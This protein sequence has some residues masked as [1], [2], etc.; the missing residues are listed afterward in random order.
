VAI[1][2]LV[3]GLAVTGVLTALSSEVYVR[4]QHRLLRLRARDATAVLTAALPSIQTPL[5]SAA[6]LA[7][8]TGGSAQKFRAFATPY[9][10]PKGQFVS[11]SIWNLR[12]LSRGP[13]AVAGAKPYLAMNSAAVPAFFSRV[14]RA[15][16]LSV[17]NF[18]HQPLPRLGYGYST[19]ALPGE[20]AA[21]AE[22]PLPR[23]KY[24]PVGK[25]SSFGG[26][27]YAIYLQ[28]TRP[29]DLL[30]T[31][32]HHLPLAGD[33]ATER[34]AFGDSSFILQIATVRSL[35][36]SLPQQLPWIIAIGGTLISLAAA[37][38]ALRL[39]QRRR[40]AEQLAEELEVVAEENQRLFTEQRTIAQTLQHALLP[41]ALPQLPGI[42]AS[43]RYEAGE[44]TVDIGGDWYDVIALSEGCL[45]LVVGD[46]SGRGLRA[47]TTMA[48]LRFAI[49]AYATQG[50]PPEVIL[51]KLSSLVNVAREGQLATILCAKI[52]VARRQVDMASAGHLPALLIDDGQARFLQA[53]TGIPVGVDTDARYA[54]STFELPGGA[55]LLAYTD[56]LVEKRGEHLDQGLGRLRDDAV[57][58][59][60]VALPDL[61][62]NLVAD[63]ASGP[64][65]DDIAI[66]GIRWT[67]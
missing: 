39:T 30:A 11:L 12:D 62:S 36:G 14:K 53:P 18:L 43:G 34:V 59:R 25:G 66:V 52:D 4:N 67:N 47:A 13:V 64:A 37:G 44:R 26:L 54:A 8:A 46:V 35:S 15:T 56:G 61:L 65:K 60:Q 2:A 7:D 29:M 21:Y 24:A 10:L 58:S 40:N 3:I 28:Q 51:S 20:Y 49:H 50:D 17:L 31:N 38:S 5:A 63:L 27:R 33:I 1:A 19:R 45:L 16:S 6:E 9:L 55:T 41:E 32:V 22:S 57:R 42:E 23:S 48:S